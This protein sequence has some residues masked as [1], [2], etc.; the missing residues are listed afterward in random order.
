MAAMRTLAT[1]SFVALALLAACS[2]TDD[3]TASGTGAGGAAMTTVGSGGAPGAGGGAPAESLVTRYD[4][5][6]DL[7]T[8]AAHSKLTYSSPPPDGNCIGIA[9]RL[10][11]TSVL[12]SGT[13]ATSASVTDELLKACGGA[14]AATDPFTLEADQLVPLKTFDKLDVGY[15]TRTDMAGGVFSYLLSWVGGCSHFGPCDVDPSR[16]VELHFDIEHPKGTVVLCPGLRTA[17]ATSTRCDIEDTL[18]PTYSGFGFAADPKWVRTPFVTAAGTELVFFEVPGGKLRTSLDPV[19]VSAF[20]TWVTGL[21]GPLPYGPELRFAGGPTAWLGFEHPANV[22]LLEDLP[23]LKTSYADATMHVLMHE[24]V[25][26]W[27]GDRTTLASA[28][29][30]VWKEATAEYLAYVFEDEHRPKVEAESSLAYWDAISLQSEHYP[31]PTDAPAVQTFYGDVYGPGPMV[32]FVQLESLLGRDAVLAGLA[33]FLKDAG[34]KDVA[35]LRL[36]LEDAA[37]LDLKDYFEVWVFGEGAPEW[38]TF[39]VA[40]VQTG[41]DVTVT[42][43]QNNASKKLYGCRVEV[44]VFGATKRT[45]AHLDFGLAPASPTATAHVALSEALLGHELDPRHR[46]VGHEASAKNRVKAPPLKVWPL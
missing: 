4:Y 39:E 7:A 37:G 35:S 36:A 26:Q 31:R 3:T 19:S 45:T 16:L 27:A 30:F 9:C 42:V 33:A 12:W 10:P 43:T 18:A 22:I 13:A 6:F 28:S 20:I 14:L 44:D 25:H 38:P 21:L 41:N 40:T 29:D 34:A 17:G 1:P 24:T 11:V 8:R 32:L 23:D 46:V 2:S 15:M 5:R